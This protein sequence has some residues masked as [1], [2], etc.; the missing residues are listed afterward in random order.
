MDNL[1]RIYYCQGRDLIEIYLAQS[2]NYL[3][4]EKKENLFNFD[5]TK[6]TLEE[7]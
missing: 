5:Q 6:I 2:T 1:N 4:F 3:F 7:L